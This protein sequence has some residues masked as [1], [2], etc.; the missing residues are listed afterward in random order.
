MDKQARE[1]REMAK[2]MPF[3]DRVR[4]FWDY[5]KWHVFAAVIALVFIVTT[6]VQVMNRVEYDIEIAYYGG[7]YFTEEQSQKL[8]EYLSQY[9]EDVDGNG[10]INVNITVATAEAPGMNGAQLTEYQAAIGQKFMAEMAARTYDAYIFDESYYEY[11]GP[12]SDFGMIESSFDMSHVEGMQ[13]LLGIGDQPLYWCTCIKRTS[14]SDSKSEVAQ[15]K[16][17]NAIAAQNAVKGE[18]LN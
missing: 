18:N 11:A 16:Y 13:E 6:M 9:I 14:S 7:M 4:H 5:H 2:Q 15:K 12:D 17:D 10:E 1:A 3:G 8:K